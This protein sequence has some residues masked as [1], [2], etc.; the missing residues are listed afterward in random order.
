MMTDAEIKEY[1]QRMRHHIEQSDVEMSSEEL[2]EFIERVGKDIREAQVYIRDM[3]KEKFEE[4]FAKMPWYKR[5]WVKGKL[6]LKRTT[7]S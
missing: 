6:W 1:Q 4:H 5:W 3:V 2:D 7:R